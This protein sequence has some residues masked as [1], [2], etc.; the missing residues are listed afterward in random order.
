MCPTGRKIR[1]SRPSR[2]PKIRAFGVILFLAGAALAVSPSESFFAKSFARGFLETQPRAAHFFLPDNPPGEETAEDVVLRG[3]SFHSCGWLERAREDYAR[4][5]S[6][7]DGEHLEDW[8]AFWL[9]ESIYES[10]EWG[11]LREV[12]SSRSPPW[13]RFWG[14][15]WHFQN[16]EYDSA[17][18]LFSPLASGEEGQA[19]MRLMSA[20]LRALSLT[21]IGEVD[22][23][24]EAYAQILERYPRS[25][26][27]GEINYRIGGIAF[28]R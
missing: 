20:Y 23:A 12:F 4:A 27:E 22:S 8:A 2:S 3:F 14:A 15:V 21:R 24:R 13:G 28:T 11:R 7:G 25:L 19:I 5:V 9:G 6:A 17:A 1:R 26:L 10:G 18:T 16:A